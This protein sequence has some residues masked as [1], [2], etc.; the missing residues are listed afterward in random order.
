MNSTIGE[1]EI[2]I[3]ERVI[4]FFCKILGYTYLDHWQERQDNSNIEKELLTDWLRS[5]QYDDTIITKVLYELEKAAALGATKTLVDANRDVYG[6]LR[7]G[8]NVQP[9][10]GKHRITVKLIDWEHPFNN[11]F[12]IAEEVTLKG[13]DGN[14]RPDLVLYINGIAIGVLELKRSTVSVSEGIRQNL[15]NQREDFI[16]WFFATV[17][18]VM[19]GNET[20]GLHYGVIKTPEK[21]WLRWK[22]AEAHPDA[23]GNFLLRELSQICNKTRL[24]DIL[25]N[26]IVFDGNTKKICR[27]N[28]FFGVKAAQERVKRRE[29]GIIWHT[30]GQRQ[31]PDNGLVSKVNS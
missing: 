15:T 8:V 3:Q 5:W 19:A 23:H 18:L 7:Y 22:E 11:D 13:K 1:R 9:G 31:K 28:Q 12:G 26:F 17:Q 16:E 24:L 4:D 2:R 21:H 6:L 20:Q 29:G 30:Q 27:H 14:K 25:H 10:T